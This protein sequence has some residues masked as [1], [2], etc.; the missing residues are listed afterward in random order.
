M[1]H[2]EKDKKKAGKLATY[3]VILLL[4]VIIVIIIAA[5]ADSREKTFQM[6]IKE[7]TETNITIQDEIVTLKDENYQLQKKVEELEKTVSDNFAVTEIN[8]TLSEIWNLYK[9]GNRT[10]AKTKY[11]EIDIN[12]IPEASKA[13]Y[14][15]IGKA[16]GK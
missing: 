3:S 1:T 14:E 16:I 10:D 5:M 15:A 6:K 2:L 8:N 9:K 13:Y 12:T 4:M 7:T 11:G